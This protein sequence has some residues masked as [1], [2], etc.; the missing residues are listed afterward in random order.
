MEEIKKGD[1]V[2]LKSGGP[3]M[4]VSDYGVIMPGQPPDKSMVQC[5]WFDQNTKKSDLFPVASLKKI[6]PKFI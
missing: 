4:T 6:G 5:V 1:V 2:Q 3:E